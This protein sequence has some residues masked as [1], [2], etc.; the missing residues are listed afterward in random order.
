MTYIDINQELCVNCERC[1][2]TCPQ[3]ALTLNKTTYSETHDIVSEIQ[4]KSR[5]NKCIIR[6][7]RAERRTPSFDDLTVL[8][9][10]ISRPPIDK[11]R[12]E[13]NTKVVI[14]DRYAEK[15]LKI[16][17]PVL[18]PAMSF[19][20]L[21]IEAKTGFAI[22][23]TNTGTATNTG[24]GGMHPKERECADKLISQY[25]SGR[26]GVSA[27]YLN[28]S[29]AIEIKIG[30][31][32]KA[33]M[34]G[35]LSSEKITREIA[36]I[37]GIPPGVD[38]LSPSRHIDIVG[39]EDLKM[40]I[41]QLREIVSWKIPVIVK[42]SAG[43]VRDD[44]AIAAKA[45]ADAIAIDG[46]QAGTGAGPE[47]V[48]EHAGIPTMPA[49]VEAA[50][51]LKELGLKEEISLIVGGGIK[52]GADVTKALALGADA[53][54]IGTGAMIAMGCTLCN[55]CH[56]GT[57]PEGITTQRQRNREKLNP[58]KAGQKITNYLNTVTDEVIALTQQAGNTDVN[59]LEKTSLKA[60]T[61][62]A[63]NMTGLQTP[64]PN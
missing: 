10:Q 64:G 39:P 47:I 28:N 27:G 19:G 59:K 48:L 29:E 49:T 15:P 63:A 35:H 30:Q 54:Y 6:G 51:A 37:R 25:A 52:N 1:I 50:E 44:V 38:A 21:S 11:Y 60:L 53:C 43:R 4:A 14:G 26:F 16:D 20:A 12:E 58:K 36:E 31:G 40:K 46:M 17:I 62:E 13:C 55:N 34:G 22:A 57:C 9:A 24:E 56:R 2:E 7:G 42:F 3:N 41:R 18:L 5:S 61:T 45:G 33:G 32:A 23:A 8:P